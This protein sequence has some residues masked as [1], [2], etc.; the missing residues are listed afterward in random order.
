MSCILQRSNFKTVKWV[1]GKV[2]DEGP[3]RVAI[4][5]NAFNRQ[6]WRVYCI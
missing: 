6:K 5:V 1:R 3:K 2:R 4:G